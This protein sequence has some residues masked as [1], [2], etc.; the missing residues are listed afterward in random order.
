MINITYKGGGASRR[1]AESAQQA[2]YIIAL[3]IKERHQKLS[4]DRGGNFEINL[5]SLTDFPTEA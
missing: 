1:Q 2:I 5:V 4:L 3:R